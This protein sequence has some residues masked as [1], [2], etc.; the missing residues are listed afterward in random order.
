M[1]L[2]QRRG[3]LAVFWSLT[4]G[5]ALL[6][7]SRPA[8]AGAATDAVK[9]RQQEVFKLLEKEAENKKKIQTLFDEW[10]DYE[11]LAKGALGDEWGKLSDT[12][13]KEFVGLLKQLVSRAVERNLKKVLPYNIEYVGEDAKADGRKVVKTKAKHKTNTREEPIAIDFVVRDLGGGKFR[14]VDV[15]TDDDISLVESYRSQFVPLLKKEGYEAL[16]KKM[17][18]KISKGQ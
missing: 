13:K 6:F 8:L 3:L 5:L 12:Q 1:A 17:R 9:A 7:V 14:L 11:E 16:A 4:L 18:E 10:I 2:W 15:I